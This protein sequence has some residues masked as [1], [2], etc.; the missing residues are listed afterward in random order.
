MS[1]RSNVNS[2]RIEFQIDPTSMLTLWVTLPAESCKTADARTA[3]FD[4]LGERVGSSPAIKW[5]ALANVLP[6]GAGPQ[7]PLA[8]S[9]RELGDT[10]PIVSVV[11]ASENYFQVLGV[12]LVSGRAFTPVDGMPGREAAIVNQRFVRMFFSDQEPIGAHPYRQR[13]NALARDRRRRDD[14]AAAGRR[15]RCGSSRVPHIRTARPRA[16]VSSSREG[17]RIPLRLSRCFEARSN[18]SI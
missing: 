8:I 11:A 14:G 12:P 5:Y 3:F 10:A 9:G 6:Y 4:R 17:R 18:A 16:A 1:V 7:Q 2:R 13:R 15:A